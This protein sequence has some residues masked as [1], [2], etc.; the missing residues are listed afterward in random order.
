MRGLRLLATIA[1]LWLPPLTASGQEAAKFFEDNCSSCH[2]IGGPPGDAPDLKDVTK[3]RDRAWLIQFI[4]DPQEAAEHDAAARALVTKYDDGMPETED[5]SPEIIEAVLRYIEQV[6][7]AT[8]AAATAPGAAPVRAATPTDIAAGRDLYLGRRPLAANGPS[9]VACHRLT[10]GG[11]RGG[12]LGPDLTA[13]NQR[14]G[15]T[16]RLSTWLNRPP[17]R[18]MRAV[19]RDRPLGPEETF[20]IA[21]ML[22]DANVVR[23]VPGGFGTRAFV[24]TGAAGA[25]LVLLV[26]GFAWSGRMHGVRRPL[27]EKARNLAGGGR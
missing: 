9:C 14:I 15:G 27:V 13:V 21:A 5:A 10:G 16:Q 2:E 20:A 3:R 25:L 18:V 19:F 7:A 26:M 11:V 12:M 1:A 24:A 23:P 8:P 6:S 17:T 4:L 22:G